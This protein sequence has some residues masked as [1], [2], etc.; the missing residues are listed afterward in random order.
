MKKNNNK[1]L[2][3]A[4]LQ[5][6]LLCICSNLNRPIRKSQLIKMVTDLFEC[7]TPR[8][9]EFAL[10]DLIEQDMLCQKGYFIVTP[11]FAENWDGITTASDEG[12]IKFLLS[13]KEEIKYDVYFDVFEP[14][15]LS[16]DIFFKYVRATYP[17]LLE[18]DTTALA[19]MEHLEN[20]LPYGLNDDFYVEMN[21]YPL[22]NRWFTELFDNKDCRIL[23]LKAD[24]HKK[25]V[26]LHLMLLPG[27]RRS[28]AEAHEQYDEFVEHIGAYF[29]DSRN[30]HCKSTLLSLRTGNAKRKQKR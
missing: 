21:D 15:S 19:Y 26:N 1:T 28:Y 17:A 10:L 12:I 8:Q 27:R 11:E 16:T 18:R 25:Y 6:M 13:L 22:P 20:I 5:K 24:I 7:N 9:V 23:L 2:E 3:L 29:D 4:K 30:I 14:T